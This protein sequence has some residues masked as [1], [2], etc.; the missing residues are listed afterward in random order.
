MTVLEKLQV[1]EDALG[2]EPG[3]LS[4]DTKLEQLDEW[5]S[6]G[7]IT[8]IAMFDSMFE[9]SVTPQ[10]IKEFVT[11]KDILEKMEG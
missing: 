9:K 2:V 10:E 11:V 1:L 7:V 5:D 4:E 8:L 6:I 3:T